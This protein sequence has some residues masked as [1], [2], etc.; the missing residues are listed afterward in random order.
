M[1]ISAHVVLALLL[2]CVLLSGNMVPAAHAAGRHM[3]SR[4]T[5]VV[6]GHRI[7]S[8]ESSFTGRVHLEARQTHG[9]VAW[10]RGFVGMGGAVR[11]WTV[12]S[13]GTRSRAPPR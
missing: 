8:R 1:R 6:S 2:G 12:T 13:T 4:L 7:P 9:G 10:H 5:H 11:T 3:P